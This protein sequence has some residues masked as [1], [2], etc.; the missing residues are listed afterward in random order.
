MGYFS[1]TCP[2]C[3]KSI[4]IG[5]RV[6]FGLPECYLKNNTDRQYTE[7]GYL[8][9]DDITFFNK[10][11]SVHYGELNLGCEPTGVYNGHGVIEEDTNWGGS[12]KFDVYIM[13]YVM[14]ADALNLNDAK[15]ER[16]AREMGLMID[17]GTIYLDKDN[18]QHHYNNKPNIGKWINSEQ[19]EGNFDTPQ[20][21]SG[22][23][24]NQLIESGEWIKQKIVAHIPYPIK[25]F[26]EDCSLYTC[27]AESKPSKDCPHQGMHNPSSLN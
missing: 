3:D 24:P 6:V 26:H 17:R 14:N 13:L 5:D 15:T 12:P 11:K 23:T 2:K 21:P 25:M 20:E 8:G 16:E 10:D 1:F 9:K 27:Y 19:F 7:L 22:K 4:L 18:R